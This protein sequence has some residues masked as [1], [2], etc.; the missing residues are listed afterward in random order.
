[1]IYALELSGQ[2]K[3]QI[4]KLKRNEPQAFRKV[5]L[6]LEELRQHPEYGTGKPERLRGNRSGQWSRRITA[7]H[8]LVYEIRD[9]E[10]LVYVVS[11]YGHYD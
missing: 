3:E 11:S 10:V 1:M 7:K 2:A 4:L 9:K 8:R 5:A 6:L